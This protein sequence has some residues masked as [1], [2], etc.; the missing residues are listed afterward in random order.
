M[1]MTFSGVRG[2][3]TLA[4]AFSIPFT[5][6]DGSPFP[7]RHLI[8]FLAAGVIL[9]TLILASVLLPLFIREKKTSKSTWTWIQRFSMQNESC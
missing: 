1:L 5:L 8:I 3:V 2:A 6:A 7:E 4:G 9:C